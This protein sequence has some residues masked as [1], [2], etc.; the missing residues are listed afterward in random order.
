MNTVRNYR[1][2]IRVQNEKD[3][4][5]CATVTNT[6]AHIMKNYREIR[7]NPKPT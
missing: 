3:N 2:F 7:Y 6:Y 5:N 1:L 4:E